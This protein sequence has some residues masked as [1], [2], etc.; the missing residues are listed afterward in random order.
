[1]FDIF[2]TSGILTQELDP[3]L[4]SRLPP[5]HNYSAYLGT[6][7]FCLAL[8]V[9][10]YW[11]G[12]GYI[13]QS[14][15]K[16]RFELRLFCIPIVCSQQLC[17]LGHVWRRPGGSDHHWSG[18]RILQEGRNSGGFAFNSDRKKHFKTHSIFAFVVVN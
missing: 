3:D 17:G 8:I 4:T 15:F 9:I 1:M 6:V 13:I 18:Q 12:L 2:P 11:A 5:H 14:I 16:A 7:R 10:I